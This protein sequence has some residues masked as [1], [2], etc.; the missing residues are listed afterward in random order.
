MARYILSIFIF[1]KTTIKYCSVP[2]L[3]T[4]INNKKFNYLF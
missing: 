1:W 4:A 3:E 2:I